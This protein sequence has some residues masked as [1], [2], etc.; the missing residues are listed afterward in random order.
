MR[1]MDP[2]C[3][4]RAARWRRAA[5]GRGAPYRYPTAAIVQG[6]DTCAVVVQ[7]PDACAAAGREADDRAGLGWRGMMLSGAGALLVF[8]LGPPRRTRRGS[9]SVTVSVA[10]PDTECEGPSDRDAGVPPLLAPSPHT[11]ALLLSNK[12]RFSA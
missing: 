9:V 2:V 8:S 6:P 3:V 5:G 7:G 11:L 1:V 4:A 12:C 10:V